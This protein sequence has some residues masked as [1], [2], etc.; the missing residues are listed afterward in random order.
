MVIRQI[1]GDLQIANEGGTQ[2]TIRAP[3]ASSL[4]IN[5]VWDSQSV[6]A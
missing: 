6:R 3:L 4:A 2:F 5:S 1:G